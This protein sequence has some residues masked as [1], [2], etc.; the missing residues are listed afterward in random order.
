MTTN[1]RERQIVAILIVR[2]LVAEQTLHA[3]VGTLI[4]LAKV[5]TLALELG[6]GGALVGA[7]VGRD[8]VRVLFEVVLGRDG[9]RVENVVG[10][11]VA[12]VDSVALAVVGVRVHLVV[13][14][15]VE[16]A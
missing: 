7:L 15:L 4:E 10:E 3:E 13:V 16:D 6:L 1:G 2:V 5:K 11:R 12:R 9:E 14:E 8:G